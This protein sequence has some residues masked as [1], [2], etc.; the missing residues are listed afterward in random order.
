ML[1]SMDVT[2]STRIFL[3]QQLTWVLCLA[4]LGATTAKAAIHEGFESTNSTWKFAAT[5]CAITKLN[6][7][8][9]LERRY[10]GS[11]SER[12]SFLAGQGTHVYLAHPIQPARIIDELS[13][14]VWVYGEKRGLQLR[15]VAVLPRSQHPETGR[16]LEAFLYG[17]TYETPEAWQRLAIGEFK[18]KLKR[19]QAILR[20][21]F[22]PQ[23]DTREAYI[24]RIEI[25]AYGG[26]G[27]NNL[28]FD[29]LEVTGFA[30][31]NRAEATSPSPSARELSS[32]ESVIGKP[33][34]ELHG[35]VLTVNRRPFVPRMVEY[36]GESFHWLKSLGFNAVKL[37]ASPTNEQLTQAAK[38]GMWI[39]A[40]PPFFDNRRE[41]EKSY[42]PVLAWS[43]GNRLSEREFQATQELA[44]EIRLLDARNRRP[45]LCSPQNNIWNYSGVAN[46][47]LLDDSPLLASRSIPDYG[48]RLRNRQQLS[49]M[50]S[51]FWAYIQTEPS[52]A[53]LRQWSALGYSGMP[54]SLEPNQVRALLLTAIASGVRGICFKS[55]APLDRVESRARAQLLQ[56]LNL[57]MILL[58]PW[59]AAAKQADTSPEE[60]HAGNVQILE[61]D[62]SRLVMIL[63]PSKTD[64][65][66]LEPVNK[67]SIS[68]D[69]HSS[70][71]TEQAYAI[72]PYA[73]KSI[74]RPHR[75]R[76]ILNDTKGA[77]L[78]VL[79]QDPLVR[80]YLMRHIASHRDISFRLHFSLLKQQLQETS[81][82]A[83]QLQG[84]QQALP[85]LDKR[86]ALA[87]NY[88]RRGQQ[89]LLDG[90]PE[91]AWQQVSLAQN[92][93]RVIRRAAWQHAIAGFPSPVASPFCTTFST[94]PLHWAMA[95]KM[96]QAQWSQN[97]LPAGDFESL[98]HLQK[99][100]WQ[101]HRT[102]SE[103]IQTRVEISLKSQRSGRSSLRLFATPVDLEREP[104]VVES[105]PIQIV[106]APINTHPGQIVRIHG[107]VKIPQ[108]IRGSTNGLT[109]VDSF[110]QEPLA[111]RI[112]VTKDW[113]EFT[114]YRAATTNMPLTVAF[115]LSGF[116]EAW[117]DAV[118][119]S[120]LQEGRPAAERLS[121]RISATAD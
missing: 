113:R 89:L 75:V 83:K 98:E 65:Y 28:W 82:V 91:N 25:N 71:S 99:S 38:V 15:A 72:T 86:L 67:K 68:V 97:A 105:P 118:S 101:Q 64:Q 6:H 4:S 94:L 53:L 84:S 16:P 66:V 54:P 107:W 80:N 45:L 1:K 95:S 92:E 22:G 30:A 52:T 102:A 2:P 81:Q 50:E 33:I 114:L 112:Q 103:A 96:R 3:A 43:L 77:K 60:K 32:N 27:V 111:E 21:Q 93:I 120:L 85:N 115:A 19:Q 5:D 119:I 46:I 35:N 42:D 78:V 23:V 90:D 117:L 110:G 13:V 20:S 26:P 7:E 63:Q 87:N 49:R 74:R 109:I 9:T 61:T 11:S 41:V 34:V 70:P 106:T 56:L 39:V 47:V 88:L 121:K 57:E 48:K 44:N 59:I 17:T 76:L 29:D 31:A 40:P 51:S 62:R 37:P 116:G 12:V 10:T 14:S 24:D 73:L 100:H 79:T 104:A 18:T 58:E 8:R 36:H 108:S 69:L 55:T